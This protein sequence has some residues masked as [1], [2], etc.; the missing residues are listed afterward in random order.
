MCFGGRRCIII[1][2]CCRLNF[3][4]Q[5]LRVA[6]STFFGPCQC[7]CEHVNRP[8]LQIP[9]RLKGVLYEHQAFTCK[10]FEFQSAEERAFCF[11]LKAEQRIRRIRSSTWIMRH[12]V[13][14]SM[15]TNFSRSTD[16]NF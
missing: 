6:P 5:T 13:N 8:I 7:I 2:D 1:Y 3:V 16:P 15:T 12:K 14:L 11:F 4:H 9:L 10:T